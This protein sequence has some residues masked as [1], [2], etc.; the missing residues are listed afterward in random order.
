MAPAIRRLSFTGLFML[1]LGSTS[2]RAQGPDN[3]YGVIFSYGEDVTKA[4]PKLADLGVKWCR[5]WVNIKDWGT[6]SNNTGS[7]A[8][9]NG[10]KQ[11]IALKAAGYRVILEINSEWGKVPSRGRTT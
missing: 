8:Y 10:Y 2:L 11:A 1:L 4:K 7:A 3:F 5:V 9:D 6:P